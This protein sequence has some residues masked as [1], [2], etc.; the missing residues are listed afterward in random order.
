MDIR[1]YL[2]ENSMRVIFNDSKLNEPNL[3]AQD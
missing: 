3:G 2:D 1:S